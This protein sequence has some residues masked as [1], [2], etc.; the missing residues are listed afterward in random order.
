LLREGKDP[1]AAAEIRLPITNKN[2]AHAQ[3]ISRESI[4]PHEETRA[5]FATR[6][7]QLIP[8]ASP[9]STTDRG[10]SRRSFREFSNP[11]L[12]AG[13]RA[14]GHVVDD[15]TEPPDGCV[16]FASERQLYELAQDWP[17]RRLVRLWNALPGVQ[18]VHRFENR[19]IAA[20][21]L[22]RAL[23][24][25][26]PQPSR[27][28]PKQGKRVLKSLPRENSKAAAIL[29]LLSRPQGA[30]VQELMAATQWQAHSVRGFISGNLGKKR[31]LKVR[32]FKRDGQHAYRV[33]LRGSAES[34]VG[35]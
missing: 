2:P 17:L 19:T 18:P 10:G 8:T 31:Q 34:A 22:W 15:R 4:D 24:P 11:L 7:G 26:A 21:R 20:S 25:G 27:S 35:N 30:T 32:S 9:P 14:V 28:G 12:R 5:P 29:Q 1:A 13:G 6:A 33:L 3:S 23:Q 16:T